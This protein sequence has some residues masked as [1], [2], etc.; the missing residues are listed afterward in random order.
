MRIEHF[1]GKT[2]HWYAVFSWWQGV[3]DTTLCDKVC[4][5]LATG[6]WFS[7]G[8]MVSSTNKTDRQDITEILLKEALNAI[9]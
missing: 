7:T 2:G 8:T 1:I 5:R 3:F 4:Q 6:Q 9:N